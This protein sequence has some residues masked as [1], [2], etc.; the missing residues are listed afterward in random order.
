MNDCMN[1]LMTQSINQ[2]INRSIKNYIL[3]AELETKKK[4]IGKSEKEKDG[5]GSRNFIRPPTCNDTRRNQRR[6]ST[7]SSLACENA[8]YLV[9]NCVFSFFDIVQKFLML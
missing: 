6:S 4:K 1:E 5:I 7:L 2:L 9:T 8:I 3:E